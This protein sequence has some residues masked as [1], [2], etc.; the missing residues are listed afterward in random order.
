MNAQ[1]FSRQWREQ[2][3]AA[4]PSCGTRAKVGLKP[5]TPHSAAGSLTDPNQVK[6]S[7]KK[8]WM[9]NS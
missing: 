1:D 4:H 8:L 6:Q 5:T 9:K 2:K 7:N 3:L